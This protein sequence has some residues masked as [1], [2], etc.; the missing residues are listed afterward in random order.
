M[1]TGIEVRPEGVIMPSGPG[2]TKP[3]GSAAVGGKEGEVEGERKTHKPT[4]REGRRK[5]KRKRER[6]RK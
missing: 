4:D 6:K 3:V 1:P 2:V 5:K